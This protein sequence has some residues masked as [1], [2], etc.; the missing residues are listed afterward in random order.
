MNPIAITSGGPS[1]NHDSPDS[2]LAGFERSMIDLTKMYV[3]TS[4]RSA[5]TTPT[6]RKRFALVVS[7][8]RK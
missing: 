3:I 5:A 6:S 2:E 8:R 1:P 7:S 4:R